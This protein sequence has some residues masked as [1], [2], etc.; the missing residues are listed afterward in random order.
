MSSS[1][2]TI[3][4]A[5]GAWQLVAGFSDFASLLQGA[6]FSVE[7]VDYP[8][9]GGTSSPLPGLEDD[10]AATRKTL[11]KVLEEGKEVL[12][13]CH[14]YGGVVGSCAVEGYSTVERKKEGK[15][16]GVSL[17]VYMT[18]FM[19]P[20]GKSLLDMLN[21]KPLPWMDVQGD[22]TLAVGSMMRDV[23]FNDMTD[24]QVAKYAKMTSHSSTSVFTTPSTFE[25]WSN[26]ITCAYIFCTEDNALFLPIQQQMVQQLGPDPVTWSL[27]AGHCPFQSIPDQLLEVM[28]KAADRI[29]RA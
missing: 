16:G 11:S 4:I 10:V 29:E 3:V 20:K 24:E 5:P 1:K 17:V 23:V 21:G 27:Q 18:A 19:I 12:L 6:G 13:L 22:K 28:K 15:K 9:V 2:P 7:I 14:S 26:G 25:P 8:S